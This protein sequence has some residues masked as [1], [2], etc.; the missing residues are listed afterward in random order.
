MIAPT[1]RLTFRKL[2]PGDASLFAEWVAD[3]EAT[4]YSLSKWLTPKSPAEVAA[5]LE[6]VIRETSS[7]SRGIV[8]KATGGLIGYAGVSQLSRA[9]RSGE[10]FIF[11]GDKQSWNKGFGTETTRAIVR[12]SFEA[13][14]LN[15]LML[16]VSAIHPAAITAYRRSGFQEEGVLRQACF[17][18]GRFHDKIV[19]SIL[20]EDWKN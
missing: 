8:N 15:R 6:T 18:N 9:N 1:D 13:L 7:F 17:R 5:W 11:L 19:M 14:E 10:Y 12:H 20:R 3:E 2:L 4:R 16:T